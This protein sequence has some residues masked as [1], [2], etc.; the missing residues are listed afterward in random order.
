RHGEENR[1]QQRQVK[2]GKEG[3]PSRQERL[4]EQRQQRHTHRHRNAEPVNLNLLPR[5]VSDGHASGDYR[6]LQPVADWTADSRVSVALLPVSPQNSQGPK[7]RSKWGSMQGSRSRSTRP[8]FPTHRLCWHLRKLLSAQLFLE[9]RWLPV[10]R[11]RSR[12][13]RLSGLQPC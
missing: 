12:Y 3:E 2:D 11:R 4:Q 5:C 1:Y 9:R 10:A 6:R 8:C 7:A 13:G